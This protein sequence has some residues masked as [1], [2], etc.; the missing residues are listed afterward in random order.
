MNSTSVARSR[1][2]LAPAKT[3][4]RAAKAAKRAQRTAETRSRVASSLTQAS[5]DFG[6]LLP[7]TDAEVSSLPPGSAAVYLQEFGECVAWARSQ[8]RYKNKQLSNPQIIDEFVAEYLSH[9]FIAGE[10]PSVARLVLHGAIF[11]HSLPKAR[12]SLPRSRRALAA[13]LRD[14]PQSS[15]EP[16]PE[17]ALALMADN[18]LRRHAS[19]RGGHLPSVLAVGAMVLQMDLGGRPTETL[20]LTKSN[21]I[22]PQGRKF[23][24]HG[25]RFHGTDLGDARPNK[26][27]L[28]DDTVMSRTEGDN[29]FYSKVLPTLKSAARPGERLLAPLTYGMYVAALQ[30]A[31]EASGLTALRATPHGL[32]HSFATLT[33]QRKE[34][35]L[36]GL[37]AKLRVKQLN[38]VRVYAK[39]G[40]MQRRLQAIGPSKR[41]AGATLLRD[42]DLNPFER[43][44]P[45]LRT[46]R[47]RRE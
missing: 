27:Q 1:R 2:S 19:P 14:T 21:V 25:V 32:R 39:P 7:M 41:Q 35:S 44:I 10:E 45:I 4:A 37:I 16:L 6:V 29:S 15:K 22:E 36:T 11:R 18:L 43:V 24:S 46:L 26:S 38:T 23:P 30:W 5:D 13:F 3:K 17:E 40:V 9:L 34:A 8:A 12:S 31:E 42:P 33:L 47:S 20:D 28:F